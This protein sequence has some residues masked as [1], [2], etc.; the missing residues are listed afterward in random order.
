MIKLDAKS[1][2]GGHLHD[3]VAAR[4]LEDDAV[5]K[6]FAK[7]AKKPDSKPLDAFAKLYGWQPPSEIAEWQGVLPG[8]QAV[9]EAVSDVWMMGFDLGYVAKNKLDLGKLVNDMDGLITMLTGL[10]H[11]GDD[12]SGD[13]SFIST[14][15]HP[16]DLAEVHV[17]NHENGELDGTLYY[18]L[19]DFVVSNWG[20]EDDREKP[21]K[22]FNSVMKPARKKFTVHD[23]ARALFNR[24]K[25]MWSLPAGE[26][27]Y[28]FAE[29]MARAPTFADWEKEKSLLGKMPFL[30][31]YWM[32]AHYFLGNDAA[33]S[34]AAQL[35]KKAKGTITPA[36]AKMMTALLANPKKAKLGKLGP[37]ALEELRAAVK[38]NAEENLLEPAARDAVKAQRSAGVQKADKK[39]LAKRLANGDD[40]WAL[41]SEFAD[42][43]DAHAIV[44]EKLAKK[45]KKLGEAVERFEKALAEDDVWNKWPSRWEEKEFDRRL[46]SC[47]GAAFRSG[48]KFDAD[49]KRAHASLVNT[50]AYLDDD[51]AMDSFA[52]AIETLRMD[53]PRLEY[54]VPGLA[55]SKHPRAHAIQARAAW[56]FFEFFDATLKSRKKTEKEGPTLNN[57]FKVDS[58]L[59]SS[60]M[61]AIRVGDDES[62]KLVDKVC[63]I[64]TNMRILGPAYASAFRQV[65][66]KKLERHLGAVG[67]YVAAVDALEADQLP[68]YAH[69]NFAE[70]CIA[71][72]KVAA[73]EKAEKTLR[74]IIAKKRTTEQLQLDI[75]GGAL[76]GLLLLAPKDPELI[77]SAERILGNR[78][79]EERVYG[80]LRG[81]GEGKVA[82]AKEW[83]RYHL[84]AGCSSNHIGEK[85]AIQNA[86]RQALV[87]LGEPEAP[88]FD[89]ND[90]F[91]NKLPLKDLPAALLDQQKYLT[92]WIFKRIVEKKV[93]SPDVIAIGG[94]VLEDAYRWSADDPDRSLGCDERKEGLKAM[95]FQGEDAL[96]MLASLLALPHMA[97]N[98]KTVVLYA[99]S[100]ITNAPRCLADLAKSTDVLALVRKPTPHVLGALDLVCAWAHTTLGDAAT[101]AVLDAVRHRFAFASPGYDHWIEQE[102]TASRLL[103]LAT[104]LSGGKAVLKELG[105]LENY[106]VKESIERAGRVPVSTASM[107]DD[108]T[109]TLISYVDENRSDP[110]YTCSIALDGK[111]VML[112][113]KAEELHF[114]GIPDHNGYEQHAALVC[115]SPDEARDK[116]N[117]IAKALSAIG[118]ASPAAP[119]PKGKRK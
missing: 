85:P 20:D 60:L 87:A 58:Y 14:L 61:H 99:M 77:A 84:Y 98:D 4:M 81:V 30:A 47:I 69:Y 6:A 105:K 48:L 80:A 42:D 12:P 108:K 86:A 118:F 96:P 37:K 93:Q 52:M 11:F 74:E 82:E 51:V 2:Q 32:L 90:E 114:E 15:P 10:E 54:L 94:R 18:S 36:L 55:K 38:K 65:G 72:A 88:P 9:F 8:Y 1:M 53:D 25:W 76:G 19:A 104:R 35:A 5:R 27:G 97:G 29:D 57:M 56:R 79:R 107:G 95:V 112:G 49:H 26:P 115:A 101:E 59:L 109:L 67:G 71:A 43:M 70:A 62:E 28:H 116:A 34:E 31:N 24:M 63:S 111:S 91:G 78:T 7:K 46:S 92:D 23:D 89:E 83:V 44:L 68:D 41:I 73:P 22:D 3:L 64:N 103:V 33:C 75:L 50:L 17:Y 113:W 45:D 21:M 40:G 39:E 66:N 16:R 13:R 117:Q 100:M 106:H 110:K 119:K 102:P